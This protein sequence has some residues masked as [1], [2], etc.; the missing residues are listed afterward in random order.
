LSVNP[1]GPFPALSLHVVRNRVFICRNCACKLHKLA[2][3]GI[4]VL[5]L[6]VDALVFSRFC[7]QFS[8]IVTLNAAVSW[9]LLGGKL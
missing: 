8:S 9:L 1:T 2:E 7:C 6:E 4:F 5:A 3:N